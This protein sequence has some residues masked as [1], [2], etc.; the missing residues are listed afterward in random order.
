MI[1][2]KFNMFFDRAGVVQHVRDGTKSVLS[3]AGAFAR[4]TMKGLI[5]SGKNPAKP[6]NP[7]KSHT[8][9]FKELIFFGYEAASQSVVIGPAFRSRQNP[10]VPQLLNDGGEAINW[11]TGKPA[12][13]Q[14]FPFVEPTLAIEA[15]KFPE[16][17]T[18]AIK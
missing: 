1:D 5:R 2:I 14:A 7:P 16:L 11:R 10:P 18:N 4:R 6:G 9:L 12:T 15:P 17:F 3:K 13:Y 8:G